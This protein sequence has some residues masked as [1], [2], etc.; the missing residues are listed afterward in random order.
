MTII[1]VYPDSGMYFIVYKVKKTHFNN[2]W[3][4]YVMLKLEI[5]MTVLFVYPNAKMYFIHYKV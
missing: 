5:V 2:K 1:F 4:R 3:I